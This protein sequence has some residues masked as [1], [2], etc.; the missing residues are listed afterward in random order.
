MKNSTKLALMIAGVLLLI[1]GVVGITYAF[2]R[3]GGVQETANTFTS[4]CL[5]ISLTNID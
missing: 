1:V 3:A 4:G 2:F 5:N